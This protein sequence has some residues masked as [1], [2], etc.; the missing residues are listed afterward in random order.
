MQFCRPY[1]LYCMPQMLGLNICVIFNKNLHRVL[2]EG[3]L[4][5]LLCCSRDRRGHLRVVLLPG[6]VLLLGELLQRVEGGA[7]GLENW[8]QKIFSGPTP[9]RKIFSGP[10]PLIKIF[11]GPTPLRKIFLVLRPLEI[12]LLFIMEFIVPDWGSVF[13]QRTISRK[14]STFFSIPPSNAYI[15]R[16][17]RGVI[18]QK[19]IGYT[20]FL[21]L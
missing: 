14:I 15:I 7:K 17:H 4:L 16:T 13:F 9:L 8:D 5:L 1:L 6:L 2:Q 10:T 12:S 21:T 19:S 11:S 3:Q 18:F 20:I